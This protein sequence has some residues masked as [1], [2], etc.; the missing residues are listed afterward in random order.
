LD[1]V[2]ARLGIP[3]QHQVCCSLARLDEAEPPIETRG[4]GVRAEDLQRDSESTC[5]RPLEEAL[6]DRRAD[7]TSVVHRRDLNRRGPDAL[8]LTDDYQHPYRLVPHEHDLDHVRIDVI[9]AGCRGTPGRLRSPAAACTR[10][11]WVG[12]RS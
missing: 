6:D 11:R 1:V 7:A 4:T 10:S 2:L 5:S 8:G 3:P 12:T 9:G